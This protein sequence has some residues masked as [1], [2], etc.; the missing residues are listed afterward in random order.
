M[1]L[2]D[3]VAIVTGG[4]VGI[5]KSIALAFA[6][7]GAHVVVAAR[8]LAP[9]EETV[10]QIKEL[11]RKS[12]AI[13][14]DVAQ[15]DQ[16]KDMVDKTITEFGQIDILVANSGIAGATKPVV[17]VDLAD[18]NDVLNVNLTGVMLC[19]REVLKHMIPRGRGNIITISSGAGRMG[20]PLRSPYAASKWGVL[21]FTYS[22]ALEV[23]EQNI[24]VNAICPGA[25]KGPRIDRVIQGRAEATGVTFAEMEKEYT[26]GTA[27]KRFV[28]AEEMANTAV[29][30]ASD[31]S[32]AITG[33]GIS[34]DGGFNIMAR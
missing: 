7:E 20:Y 13:G 15:E 18:W 12:L 16:V 32:S 25:T 3:R 2:Q 24:R 10:K 26:G 9:L 22:L 19:S 1:R 17:E 33:Q 14:T 11:G 5:G 4:G 31:E 23:G 27:L 34:V 28:F 21:G 30:L 29:F 6:K 8:T